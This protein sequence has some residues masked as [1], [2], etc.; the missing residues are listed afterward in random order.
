VP[1]NAI[2]YPVD[3]PAEGGA[4]GSGV[5]L[6]GIKEEQSRGGNVRDAA[7]LGCVHDCLLQ[8]EDVLCYLHSLEGGWG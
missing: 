8:E 3:M 5:N 2:A 7:S 6:Y 4:V 1:F